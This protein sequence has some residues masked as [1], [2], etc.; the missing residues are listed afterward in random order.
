MRLLQIPML[1]SQGRR[2]HATR[3]IH[4]VSGLKVVEAKKRIKA[5]VRGRMQIRGNGRNRV[6]AR[7]QKVRR[8][9]LMPTPCF[10][11]LPRKRSIRLPVVTM[12]EATSAVRVT[13]PRRHAV[14]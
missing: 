10:P 3:A 2:I 1:P 5:Q 13:L 14:I 7:V 11:L 12:L 8:L 6:L 9:R 4:R